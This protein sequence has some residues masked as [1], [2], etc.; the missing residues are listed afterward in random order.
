MM[1]RCSSFVVPLMVSALLLSAACGDNGANQD[2]L[3]PAKPECAG[4]PIVPLMGNSNVILSSLAIGSKDDGLD[5]DG[6]GKPDNKLSGVASL[7]AVPLKDAISNYSVVLPIEFFDLPAIAADTCVKFAIYLGDPKK[8]T[9]GD[10]KF[11][12]IQTGDCND[13]VAAIGP[14]MPEVPGNFIDDNCNGLADEM[15]AASSTDPMDRDGDGVSVAAGDCD[16]TN[17]KIKKG[18]VEICDDGLD[19]DCDGIADRTLGADGKP[20]VAC[21]P[22]DPAKPANIKL[23]PKSFINDQPSIAYRDG[24]ISAGKNGGLVLTAGPSVFGVK[25]PVSETSLLEVRI[26]GA[27]FTADIAMTPN[28]ATLTNGKLAGII[29]PVTADSIRGLEVTQVGLKKEDSLLDAAYANLL[30]LL[31]ALPKAVGTPYT[32]CLTADIDVDRD[33]LEAFCDSDITDEIKT[34]DVCID[35]NG[36]EYRDEAGKQCTDV[37]DENG[38]PRFV[39]GISVAFLFSAVPAG[40]FSR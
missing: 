16:D 39:D 12:G 34:V 26:T 13:K 15:G 31:L 20:T 10:G 9:D 7:A 36:K 40:M 3:F 30:G 14:G 33:G 2:S 18:A 23:D 22:F 28:G 6:D 24:T 35:G 11:A 21:S 37:L 25:V 8:D 29:D 19:N 32:N 4:A 27:T 1:S 38:K 17:N 5:L